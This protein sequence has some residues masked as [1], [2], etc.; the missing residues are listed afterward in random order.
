V[1]SSLLSSQMLEIVDAIAL[2]QVNQFQEFVLRYHL[3]CTVSQTRMRIFARHRCRGHD[4]LGTL[5]R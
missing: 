2:E 4:T 1:L 3:A 5:V